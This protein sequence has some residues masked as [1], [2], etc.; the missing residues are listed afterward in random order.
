MSATFGLNAQEP[1]LRVEMFSFRS[2]GYVRVENLRGATR[3]Q[4]W[5]SQKVH[6]IAEKKYPSG[7]PLDGVVQVLSQPGL[8]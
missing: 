2:D 1:S 3:I 6:V 8:V 5:S 7:R 4:T